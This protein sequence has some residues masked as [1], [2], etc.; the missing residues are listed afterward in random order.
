M[1]PF[2]TNPD[3]VAPLLTHAQHALGGTQTTLGELVG[4]TRRTV[5]R[6]QSGQSFPPVPSL[7]TIARKVHP[8]DPALAERLAAAA[9]ATL[10]GLGIVAPKPA[11][12]PDPLADPARRRVYVDSVVCAAA[13]AVDLPPG[14]VR[15]ALAIAL[16][17]A[18]ETGVSL[19]G[20]ADALSPHA[21][22]KKPKRRGA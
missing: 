10:E 8:V 5:W 1:R 3:V 6:W 7:E 13:E 15:R 14:V 22:Q 11:H 16:S 9:G 21:A 18:R 20:L 17:R 2:L 19:D 4:V 12:K